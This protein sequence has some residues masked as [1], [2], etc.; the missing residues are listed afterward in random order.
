MGE[1]QRWVV[2]LSSDR[3]LADLRQELA[4]AGLAV[5]E[6]LEEIGVVIGRGDE[7]AVGRVRALR[8]VAGV[9]RDTPID[10]G[11]PDSPSTW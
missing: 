8:G 9:A 11:G 3:P 2:T 7:A 5:D 6:E 1:Q 10:I 4:D